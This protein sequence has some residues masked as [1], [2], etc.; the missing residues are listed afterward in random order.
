V[1]TSENPVGLDAWRLRDWSVPNDHMD[2]PLLE[3]SRSDLRRLS[4][5]AFQSDSNEV[6]LRV[7]RMLVVYHN[8]DLNEPV[9]A[10]SVGPDQNST[11]SVS[12]E[13]APS[14]PWT[15]AMQSQLRMVLVDVLLNALNVLTVLS[16]SAR[17]LRF[18][19]F[20][21]FRH[22]KMW[23]YVLRQ[24]ATVVQAVALL[25]GLV[26]LVLNFMDPFQQGILL[27]SGRTFPAA[28]LLN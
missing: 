10:L 16:I 12:L 3:L 18:V 14:N 5:L 4:A 15:T 1:E 24:P 28:V 17:L 23:T 9:V 11:R 19:I 8:P 13:P 7:D 25:G 27:L 22:A 20:E 6:Q 26:R 21:I 2:V